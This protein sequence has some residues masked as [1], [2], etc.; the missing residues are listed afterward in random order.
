MII[1]PERRSI[2]TYLKMGVHIGKCPGTM[3]EEV[4]AQF[5]VPKAVKDTATA[6]A[7]KFIQLTS[8]RALLDDPIYVQM[9][10]V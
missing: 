5:H 4:E 2:E 6:T 7:H 10:L 3:H 9:C 8:E 1:M